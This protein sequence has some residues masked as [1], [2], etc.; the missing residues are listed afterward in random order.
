M[1]DLHDLSVTILRCY[2][3]VYANSS[4][5]CTAR[6][7]NY[8]PIESFLLTYP[9]NGFKSQI[10][11]LLLTAGSFWT[12]FLYALNFLCFFFL[13]L[14]ALQWL[15]S[16]AWSESQKK[17]DCLCFLYVYVYKS[18]IYI[19]IYIYSYIF[20]LSNNWNTI[21]NKIYLTKDK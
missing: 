16:L 21:F 13:Q 9:L 11:R 20:F 8:L 3:Y 18:Y 17:I 12:N 7:W 5:P 6:L 1:H 4:F 10:N 14:H 19:Y 15:F 2:K